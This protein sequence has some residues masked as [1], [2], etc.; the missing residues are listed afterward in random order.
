MPSHRLHYMVLRRKGMRD[1]VSSTKCLRS[2]IDARFNHQCMRTLTKCYAGDAFL[3]PLMQN[4]RLSNRQ[5][6]L[7][8]SR[9]QPPCLLRKLIHSFSYHRISYNKNH[10]LCL[11]LVQQVFLSSLA[12]Y[13]A[14]YTFSLNRR[15]RYSTRV[16]KT[17]FLHLAFLY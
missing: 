14:T 11:C 4:G 1:N 7:C 17:A 6:T 13:S 2:S 16:H 10:Y 5:E 15:R 3:G 8:H 12:I 9:F